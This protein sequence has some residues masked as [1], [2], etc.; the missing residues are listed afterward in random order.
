MWPE[1]GW[2]WLPQMGPVWQALA[3]KRDWSQ[4]ISTW[5][6][7]P[8]V[9]SMLIHGPSRSTPQQHIGAIKLDL[10][11]RSYDFLSSFFSP[12]R[13]HPTSFV[14]FP[15]EANMCSST[16][17]SVWNMFFF[18]IM[19]CLFRFFYL[20]CFPHVLCNVVVEDYLFFQLELPPPHASGNMSS[21]PNI[22]V[23]NSFQ[24]PQALPDTV[25]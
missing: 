19:N 3:L 1:P 2:V 22:S 5:P 6:N 23:L 24:H 17:A 21:D 8:C 15:L 18:L 16:V 14:Y 12:S 11:H 13:S 20:L 10:L 9:H 7:P 4:W 25:L